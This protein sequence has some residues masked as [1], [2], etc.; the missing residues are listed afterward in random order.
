M[1]LDDVLKLID[2]GYTRDEILSM[3]GGEDGNTS[4]DDGGGAGSGSDTGTDNIGGRSGSNA[5]DITET[6]RLTATVNELVQTVKALQIANAKAATGGKPE[7][8]YSAADAIKDFFA[9][10]KPAEK[11]E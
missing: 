11:T 5:E 6:E 2:A 8:P 1:K 4:G 3:E 10:G 9:P 7:K